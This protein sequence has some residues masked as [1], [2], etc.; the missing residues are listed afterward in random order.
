L[1]VGGGV[2]DLVEG[3]ERRAREAAEKRVAAELAN[4]AVFNEFE[5]IR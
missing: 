3:F 1:W 5:A 4:Q 2:L